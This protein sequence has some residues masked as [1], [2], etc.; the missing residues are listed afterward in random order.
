MT[1][2]IAL[3][4]LTQV[5][6]APS[7][8]P[9]SRSAPS[10]AATARRSAAS[11]RSGGSWWCSAAATAALR[12]RTAATTRS[13]AGPSAVTPACSWALKSICMRCASW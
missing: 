13:L 5:S 9:T 3:R 7:A 2:R 1:A 4:V 8:A 11:S 10:L 6:W 12:V